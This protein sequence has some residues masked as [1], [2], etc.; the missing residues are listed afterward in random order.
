LTRTAEPEPELGSTVQPSPPEADAQRHDQRDWLAGSR[1]TRTDLLS[2]VVVG[3]VVMLIAYVFRSIIVPTDPWHYVR[4]AMH[5]PEDSWVPLGYTRYGIILASIPPAAVFGNAQA[6]YYFWPLLSAG[7]LAG[8]V[9]LLGTRWWRRLAGLVAVVLM[10]SNVTVFYNLSR[11]Y[12][13]IMSMAIFTTAL[14]FALLAR[15]RRSWDRWTVGLVVMVGFLLGWGFETRETSMMAW[16]LVAV[17]LWRRGRLLR[18]VIA[19][20]VPLLLWAAL[21]V[22]IS[23][24]AYGDPFLKYHVLTGTD[25]SAT[26]TATGEL[27]NGN[28]VN[29]PRLSYFTFIPKM[30][31][32]KAGGTSMVL[33]GALAAL[34]VL[35]RH[36]GIRLMA[37]WFLGVYLVTVLAAGGL[38]PAH[39]RGRLDIARYWIPFVPPAS[40][41]VAGMVALAASWLVRRLADGEGGRWPSQ[42]VRTGTAALLAVAVCAVPVAQGVRYATSSTAFAPNGGDALEELRTYLDSRDFEGR[43]IWTD[44][45]TARILPA[46]QREPFGG[47][48]VWKATPKSITGARA[49]PATGDHVLL[50]RPNSDTC[51]F[52]LNALRP[53]TIKNP[54]GP[55]ASWQPVFTSSTGNLVLYRVR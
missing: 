5:F 39:P 33:I 48:K 9:F 34:G 11:G 51:S 21:D 45:E 24:L 22:G 28:L 3:L 18:T 32:G 55:P 2:A 54:D 26:K 1:W 27:V 25:I 12:P 53:W 30:V 13:D 10:V 38:D 19:L 50:F 42:V 36:G 29:Q 35:V 46:Y 7:V 31:W 37:W 4:A 15:D 23:A 40:L 43:R 41:V 20:A 8:A 17:V 52:C 14:V 49:K 16:P 44:W 6:A 47:D